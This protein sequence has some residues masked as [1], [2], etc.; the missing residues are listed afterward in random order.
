MNLESQ[1]E[2][3]GVDLKEIELDYSAR[4]EDATLEYFKKQG[5]VGSS[6]EGITVQ[7]V[8]KALMLDK[9]AEVN[10]FQDRSDACCRYLEA[11]FT[12]H[13]DISRE[14]ISTIKDVSP[15]S[16]KKNIREILSQS[17]ISSEYPELSEEVCIALFEAID[18]EVFISLAERFS[19][20]SYNYRSGWPDL[21][22]VRGKEVRFVEVKTHNKQLKPTSTT[23]LVLCFFATLVQNNQL[24]SGSLAGR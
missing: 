16:F 12:T 4:P 2:K 18:V 17:F 3:I 10:T 23:L 21:T 22:L 13:K 9:L 7:T 24:R 11:Q 14:I 20:D 6:N 15:K 5:F 1:C 8:L 19:E